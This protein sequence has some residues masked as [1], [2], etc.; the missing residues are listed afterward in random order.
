MRQQQGR[1]KQLAAIT[2]SSMLLACAATSDKP[3]FLRN[4]PP[5]GIVQENTGGSELQLAV[6]VR[7][8]HQSEVL[9]VGL[10]FSD[11]IIQL[12]AI[13]P[14]G[15][16]VFSADFTNASGLA[17]NRHMRFPSLLPVESLLGYLLICYAKEEKLQ[18]YLPR[19]WKVQKMEMGDDQL[20]PS[21]Q[22]PSERHAIEI[23]FWGPPPWHDVIEV[24]HETL[25][26]QI[27]TLSFTDDE[28]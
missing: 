24:T 8:Q 27:R 1:M 22:V 26:I 21:G 16:P 23:R 5:S 17:V 3:Q 18:P 13:T 2:C 25:Q 12:A 15:I 14:A 6:N 19:E 20:P 9:I 11:G 10:R 4:W 7:D 28:P